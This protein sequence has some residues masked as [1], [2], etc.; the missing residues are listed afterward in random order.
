[1]LIMKWSLQVLCTAVSVLS[2]LIGGCANKE[3][4]PATIEE[5]TVSREK[6]RTI[7]TSDGEIDDADSFI[8]MLLYANEFNIEGLIY[9]SSQWHYKGDGKGTTF[10]SEMEMTREIYGERTELRWPGT[11]WMQEL[12]GEYAKIE[13][14]LKLHDDAYPS[15]DYLL[16]LIRTG[17]IEFEGEMDKDTEGSD[18]IRQKLL[19]SDTSDL[20]LQ[21][22]G[23]T[24]TIARAL[25]SIQ[26]EFGGTDQWKDVY[27]RPGIASLRGIL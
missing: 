9:S 6:P 7:I 3:D 13:A 4:E 27:S 24:N 20:Y 10:V 18:F 23:G 1:R 5:E 8:R 14:N 19:D 12:I 17:N 26:E 25:K 11:T 15:A 21:A 22:W 2:I 16:G